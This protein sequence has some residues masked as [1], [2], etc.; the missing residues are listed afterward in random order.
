MELGWAFAGVVARFEGPCFHETAIDL[1]FP[2]AQILPLMAERGIL[3]GYNLGKKYSGMEDVI[4][5]CTTETKTQADLDLFV[6]TLK[7]IINELG[8]NQHADI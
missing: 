6:E 7:S 5:V 1:P 2:A 4:L 3:A 8:T